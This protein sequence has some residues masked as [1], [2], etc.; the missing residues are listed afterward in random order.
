MKVTYPGEELLKEEK[1][2]KLWSLIENHGVEILEEEYR[3][4]K[5]Q[6][7][8]YKPAVLQLVE[9]D[10][11]WVW[12]GKWNVELDVWLVCIGEMLNL[13]REMRHGVW[14]PNSGGR[15]S[16]AGEDWGESAVVGNFSS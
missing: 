16:M 1:N 6:V 9:Y 4:A 5:S 2:R 8:V 15:F 12:Y 7:L 10:N 14:T 11:G 13:Y 3:I